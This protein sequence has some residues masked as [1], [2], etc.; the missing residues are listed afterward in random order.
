[1]SNALAIAAVTTTLRNLI[2]KGFRDDLTL[3]GGIPITAL[4]PDKARGTNEGNQVNLFLYQTTVNAA[5][6]NMDIPNQLRPG[7]S[8]MPPL[9]LNLYYLVTAYSQETPDDNAIISHHLLGRAMSVLHD[10][11]L[12]GTVEI[13]QALVGSGLGNQI[14]RVRITP[15]PMSLEEISKLWMIFQTQYRISAAYEVA[16]VLIDSRLLVRTPL[17]VLRRGRD[18]KGPTVL[19]DVIPFPTLFSLRLKQQPL[20]PPMQPGPVALPNISVTPAAR[21]KDTLVISG[22]HLDGIIGQNASTPFV[23]F[24]NQ[25]LG[26]TREIAP[27]AGATADEIQVTLPDN[28]HVNLKNPSN[29]AAGFYTLA[30]VFRESNAGVADPQGIVVGET[31]ELALSLVPQIE[32]INPKKAPKGVVTFTITCNPAVQPGQRVSL[33]FSGQEILFAPQPP[34]TTPTEQLTFV[35]KSAAPG[36]YYL[37]LRVDGVDSLLVDPAVDPITTPPVFDPNMQV[38]IT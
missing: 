4:P 21:L 6:R 22:H 12:L 28:D 25:R 27:D 14:E 35:V 33:L 2:D 5:W 10:H 7:E 9:A 17:P 38:T 24:T 34:I 11:P 26:F 19:A 36:I 15:Q 32:T 23:R 1:M 20:K 37:R 3:P 8:G 13:E 29:F 30:V 31:N 16:V 18:G